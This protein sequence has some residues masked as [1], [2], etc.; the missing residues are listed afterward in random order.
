MTDAAATWIDRPEGLAEVAAALATAPWLALDSESNSMF[1][2][3]E[4][5]CLLQ[6]NAGGRLFVIDTLALPYGPDTYA[7]LKPML[8]DPQRPCY[9]HG[10]EYDVGCL[11]RDFG[12]ALGGV[13]DS[14]QAASLLGWEKTGYGAVVERVTGIALDKAHA[15][16]DWATRPLADDALRY[17]VDDVAHLPRVC[18]QLREDIAAA[19]LVE[20][21]AIANRA[22]ESAGW[23]GGF[24]VAGFWRIKGSRDLPP[25]AQATL[26]ALWVWRDGIAQARNQPP[27][28]TINNDMLLA[29]ARNAPTNFG[30]LK[31]LGVRSWLLQEHGEALI[32]LMRQ[33]RETPPAIPP[34]PRARDVGDDEHQRETRLKDWRRIEAERR[35]VPLQV[36]LPAKALEYLKQH[37]AKHL[38]AVPQLGPK[39]IGL[40]G[41]KLRELA[42]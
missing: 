18:D 5:I 19:D 25:P 22:V 10:G 12:I 4:Q 17:A 23:S 39:R 13:W 3:R 24:D 41:D 6:L 2:Y 29:L 34:R 40:Y 9:L 7:A 37:S 26:A 35:K 21:L 15:Q 14:Q 42:G 1:V 27:G 38:D 8:E 33:C 32:E 16:Y 31:R 28:R 11:R 30:G 20:E 36:V